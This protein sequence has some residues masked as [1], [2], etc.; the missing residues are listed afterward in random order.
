MIRSQ[1]QHVWN[2]VWGRVRDRVWTR[3]IFEEIQ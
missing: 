1:N 3:E 2:R